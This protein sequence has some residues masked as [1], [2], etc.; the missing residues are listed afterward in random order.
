MIRGEPLE[1]RDRRV[2]RESA[3]EVERRVEQR[4]VWCNYTLGDGDPVECRARVYPEADS[5]VDRISSLQT[6]RGESQRLLECRRSLARASDEEDPE[7]LDPVPFDA[8]GDFADFRR[9]ESLLQFLQHW[10]ARALRSDAEGAKACR[11]HGAQQIVGR[12][13]GG[14]VRRVELHSELAASYRFAHL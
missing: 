8:L 14:E 11:L 2:E 10:V 6:P 4:A 9:V 12:G 1:A 5:E 3:G 13:R 7:R